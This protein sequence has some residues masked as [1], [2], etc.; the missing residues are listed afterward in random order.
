MQFLKKK[1]KQFSLCSWNWGYRPVSLLIITICLHCVCLTIVAHTYTDPDCPCSARVFVREQPWG[2]TFSCTEILRPTNARGV[3]VCVYA[4]CTDHWV[5]DVYGRFFSWLLRQHS[6]WSTFLESLGVQLVIS[7]CPT[8]VLLLLSISHYSF[9]N[10]NSKW[11][12]GED[13]SGKVVCSSGIRASVCLSGACSSFL[14]VFPVRFPC[15]SVSCKHF[16]NFLSP[17][18]KTAEF[19]EL[20][21][22]VCSH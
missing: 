17:H 1:F 15:I 22:S 21:F 10:L 5:L 7:A 18:L 13:L 12:G 20:L 11:Q 16:R 14:V 3:D 6:S 4:R 2:H 9:L 19:R 8:S